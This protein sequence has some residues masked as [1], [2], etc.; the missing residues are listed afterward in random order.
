MTDSDLTD[1]TAAEA[2]ARIARGETSSEKLI[3][4]CLERIAALE[5]QVQAWAFHDP[6]HALAQARAADRLSSEGKGVG[7]LHGVPVGVKDIIDTTDLPTENGCRAHQG[8][9]PI[10]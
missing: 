3:A 6:E 9:Q 5:P 8:R 2:A 4:A 1:L 10:A 7:P